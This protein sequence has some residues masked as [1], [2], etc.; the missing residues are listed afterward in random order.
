MKQFVSQ[1]PICWSWL[2]KL[3]MSTSIKIEDRSRHPLLM[4][5]ERQQALCFRRG[6]GVIA[7]SDFCG[8]MWENRTLI[9]VMNLSRE[10]LK[11]WH[12]CGLGKSSFWLPAPRPFIISTT[13]Q[14]V[15]DAMIR[16]MRERDGEK[17]SETERYCVLSLWTE[18][19]A[20]LI[21]NTN[22]SNDYGKEYN[23]IS[24]RCIWKPLGPQALPEKTIPS[25]INFLAT[26]KH[27]SIFHLMEK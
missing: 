9:T 2:S 7:R 24:D 16:N 18:S 20:P 4:P 6:S 23:N 21:K 19:F 26:R 12:S 17:K 8:R 5:A 3:V 10:A 13:I 22:H 15:E 1:S 14:C 25:L 11:V 27:N